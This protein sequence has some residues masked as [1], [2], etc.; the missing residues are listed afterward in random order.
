VIFPW[1]GM[2]WQLYSSIAARDYPMV[3]GFVL[4]TSCCFV[5][6]NC[7]IDLLTAYF[8]PRIARDGERRSSV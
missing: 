6:V 4:L 3:Q 2:G 7:C 1:P 8:D 5:L